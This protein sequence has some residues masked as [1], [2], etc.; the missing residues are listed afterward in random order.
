MSLKKAP[1]SRENKGFNG[2][3]YVGLTKNLLK[4]MIEGRIYESGISNGFSRGRRGSSDLEEAKKSVLKL[5]ST[6]V[7]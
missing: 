2:I 1:K 3:F 7:R 4:E 5:G 6:A